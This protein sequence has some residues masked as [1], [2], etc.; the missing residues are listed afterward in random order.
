MQ[1]LFLSHAEFVISHFLLVLLI[2]Y[3]VVSDLDSLLFG[4][5]RKNINI[6]KKL[7]VLILSYYELESGI[8]L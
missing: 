1:I 4:V 7:F 3:S 6:V 2:S 5:T 8:F